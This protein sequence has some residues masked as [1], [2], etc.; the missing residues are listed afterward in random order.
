MLKVQWRIHVGVPPA[1]SARFNASTNNGSL[2]L[3]LNYHDREKILLAMLLDPA[4][5]GGHEVCSRVRPHL[6]SVCIAS[7]R[8]FATALSSKTGA[9]I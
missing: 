3:D 2:G 6:R 1:K 4:K 5:S 7:I 8:G 9:S